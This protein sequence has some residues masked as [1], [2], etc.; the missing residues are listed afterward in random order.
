[1]GMAH[2]NP[3]TQ[4]LPS[5]SKGQLKFKHIYTHSPA[6]SVTHEDIFSIASLLSLFSIFL[7]NFHWLWSPQLVQQTYQNYT[8]YPPLQPLLGQSKSHFKL[9]NKSNHAFRMTACRRP[10][11]SLRLKLITK[12]TFVIIIYLDKNN[13]NGTWML[14]NQ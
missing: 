12:S 1:M 10:F 7:A 9:H 4:K 14:Q 13:S 3:I 5:P 8:S 6:M 2:S 11:S